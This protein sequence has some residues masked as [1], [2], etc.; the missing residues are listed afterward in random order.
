MSYVAFAARLQDEIPDQLHV[1]PYPKYEP[2]VHPKSS[3]SI[4][5]FR[6]DGGGS[7]ASCMT[8]GERLSK[9]RTSRGMSQTELGKGLATDGEDASKSVILGW[10]KD[11]HFPKADQLT[12]ICEKLGCTADYLLF[13]RNDAWPL[14]LV[15]F[16]LYDSLSPTQKGAAQM[17]FLEAIEKYLAPSRETAMPHAANTVTP[18]YKGGIGLLTGEI[19]DGSSSA[20]RPETQRRG[21]KGP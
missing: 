2:T 4:P 6:N 8:F 17:K 1:Q 10:E 15:P 14:D 21:H 3:Q 11:R 19:T 5:I 7:Y 20:S 12:L 9:Q 16:D 18:N 13:G